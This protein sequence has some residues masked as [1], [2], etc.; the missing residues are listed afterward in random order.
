MGSAV[1]GF[2]WSRFSAGALAG[3]AGLA[4]TYPLRLMG[5]GVFLPEL[6]V[7]FVVNRIPGE[8]ESFFVL[9]IGEGAK[10]L[11]IA[12]A[13]AVFVALPGVYALFYRWLQGRV[14]RRW[15]VG[16]LY[17]LGPAAVASLVVVPI[18]G[19]GVAGTNT[20]AGPLGTAFSQV[21]GY[22]LYATLLDYLL[23][24]VSA[25]YPEGFSLSRRQFIVATAGALGALALAVVGFGRLV[26]RESRVVFETIQ[27][28]FAKEVSTNEEFYV[29]SKN[30]VDPVVNASTW[31][32]DVG[33]M[34]ETDRTYTYDELLGR[35]NAEE[36]VT[37]EC[38]S[39][40]VGG[41][42]IDTAKWRGLP[43]GEILAEAGPLEGTDWIVFTCVD[44]YTVGIPREEAEAASTML[45]LQMNGVALPADHGFPARIIV[46]G[47]YGMFSAK[48]V[49]RIDAVVGEYEG[50]WQQKGWTNEGTI[51]TTAI[52]ATP[53]SHRTV[54]APVTLGGMA[55]AGERGISRVEV[56][57]D[58]GA[59]WQEATLKEPPLS[60]LT[61]VL[62]TY[63]WNPTSRG[64]YRI[65]VRATDGDGVPQEP[66]SE[67]PFP[68]GASGYDSILLQ[69]EPTALLGPARRREKA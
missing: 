69:V 1:R 14:P 2:P 3:A 29:V 41:N 6:A 33:G 51:R 5:I 17:T 47:L 40:E 28:L 15:M 39:N 46:P 58:G 67:S 24:D 68:R 37:L 63:R 19:G 10:I 60:D 66:Q 35:M 23:V 45:A 36:Y 11:A 54:E 32:L 52:I 64:S 21:L 50:F 30:V 8:A 42:L 56:S 48:W 27:D 22:A 57:T 16:L 20:Q 59:T 25:R 31:Q 65:H 49:T 26:A 12:V 62:W 9:S 43:L 55:F 4:L 34:V 7:N 61:W 38:V 44:G 13:I 53:P 18:L